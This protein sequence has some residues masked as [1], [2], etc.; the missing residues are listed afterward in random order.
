MDGFSSTDLSARTLSFSLEGLS[1]RDEMLFKSLVRLI[2]HLTAQKWLYRPP[3]EDYRVDLL[4][5]AEGNLPT[6]YGHAQPRK[7][8]ILSIGQGVE[9]ELLLAWPVRPLRLQAE[10][11]RI[12]AMVVQQPGS[13]A[14]LQPGPLQKAA[15]AISPQLFKLKRW[16]PPEYLNGIGGMRMATLLA[17]KAMTVEEL[18]FRTALPMPVCEAFILHLQAGQLVAQAA[19]SA[20]DGPASSMDL[21][22]A[23]QPRSLKSAVTLVKPGLFARIRAGLG[24]KTSR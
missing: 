16:P 14:Q 8:P 6:L 5:V 3:S 24:I 7:Q 10:L 19:V 17:G 1:A 21:D 15:L 23:E 22:L 18:Q 20:V 11:D 2:G 4:V 12:G 13:T 9:R